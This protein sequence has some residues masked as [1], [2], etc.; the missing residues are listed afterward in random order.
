[1]FFK[2]KNKETYLDKRKDKK[3]AICVLFFM[4]LISKDQTVLK[5]DFVTYGLICHLENLLLM[6]IGKKLNH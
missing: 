2:T 3:D 1:M 6:S 4:T 5:K